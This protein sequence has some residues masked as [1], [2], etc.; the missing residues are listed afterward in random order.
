MIYSAT[1]KE[2]VALAHSPHCGACGAPTAAAKAGW[3]RVCSGCGLQHFPR[4]DPVVIAA[5]LSPDG[6]RCLIGR[7][8][9]WPPNRFSCLAG[10]CDPG[11]TLESAVR[12]EV[13]EEA[14]VRIGDD[15]FYHS[16][17][18]W[19]NGP[20]SQLMLGCLAVAETG[21][22]EQTSNPRI[23][24]RTRR[25]TLACLVVLCGF[26]MSL[27]VPALHSDCTEALAVDTEEIESARWVEIAEIAEAIDGG[28]RPGTAAEAGFGFSVGAT[29][30]AGVLL[31]GPSAVA[32]SLLAAACKV[33]ALL[34]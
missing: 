1:G 26:L 32:H 16:S 18:P 11:E 5:V 27:R 15:C 24:T 9:S 21:A 30:G 22:E 4:T 23:R 6:Q 28:V 10:F 31:P 14:G 33:H 13:Y 3:K 8:H 20:G 2:L 12:R 29:S 17:Q 34:I 25:T 7:Q 19:P